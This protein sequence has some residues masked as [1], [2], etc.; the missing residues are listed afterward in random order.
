MQTIEPPYNFWPAQYHPDGID[1]AYFDIFARSDM[2]RL[3][4]DFSEA[5][6]CNLRFNPFNVETHYALERQGFS[7]C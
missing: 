7:A 1:G 5:R 6:A 3:G 2:I 4:P